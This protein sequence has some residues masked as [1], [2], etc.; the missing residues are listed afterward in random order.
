[1]YKTGLVLSFLSIKKQPLVL[2]MFTS[3]KF[4]K[5]N[6]KQRII[7]ETFKKQFCL[8][9]KKGQKFSSAFE[10]VCLILINRQDVKLRPKNRLSYYCEF[11]D[12]SVFAYNSI[13]TYCTHKDCDVLCSPLQ[14]YG[15][16]ASKHEIADDSVCPFC[17]ETRIF[18]SLAKNDR[19]RF[20][21]EKGCVHFYECLFNVNK[22]IVY[23][24]GGNICMT[25]HDKVDKMLI[26]RKN[27]KEKFLLRVKHFPLKRCI[28]RRFEQNDHGKW[29]SK[30]NLA[31]FFL[32]EDYSVSCLKHIIKLN[33]NTPPF[34]FFQFDNFG[35]F[36]YLITFQ[37]LENIKSEYYSSEKSVLKYLASNKLLQGCKLMPNAR[38]A[39]TL[40][41][42]RCPVG[43]SPLLARKMTLRE[44]RKIG[45]DQRGLINN[46]QRKIPK[47]KVCLDF[48]NCDF[49][50]RPLKYTMAIYRNNKCVERYLYTSEY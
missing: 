5:L 26:E 12:E 29:L 6:V 45:I 8:N 48:S 24:E 18:Y 27:C 42:H 33:K 2:N 44:F 13:L 1:M 49:K 23:S 35:E 43:E 28:Q 30:M 19:F 21:N 36:F 41:D 39:T 38:M 22:K 14:I 11:I 46:P 47:I 20:I 17:Q 50:L 7:I 31:P 4:S 9:G 37:T 25:L 32:L 10:D 34:K 15:H 16:F 40:R 3:A